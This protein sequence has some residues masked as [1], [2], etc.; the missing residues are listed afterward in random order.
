MPRWLS[1]V[2][3]RVR[4]LAAQG[5]VVFTGKALE[6][7]Q[8]LELDEQD[9]AEIITGLGPQDSAGRVRSAQTG[10]WLYL[11]RPRVADVV[12]YVKLAV[13]SVCIVVSFHQD[14]GDENDA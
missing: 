13:R 8:G 3:A 7:L 2:L 1:R 10:E 14:L 4:R 9:A 11:F 6:E 5:K 12:F